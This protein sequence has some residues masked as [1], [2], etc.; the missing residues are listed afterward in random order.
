MTQADVNTALG[1]CGRRSS[2]FGKYGP[3]VQI[4]VADFLSR[5]YL[6]RNHLGRVVYRY[7]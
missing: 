3:A 4:G 2:L 7:P 5:A 6:V 1:I